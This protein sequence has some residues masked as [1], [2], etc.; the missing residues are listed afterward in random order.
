MHATHTLYSSEA[1]LSELMPA[2]DL[3]IGAVLVPGAR[4]PRLIS[5]A[6]LRSMKPGS[7]FVDIAIDQG[8]CAETSRPTTHDDPTYVEEGV[9][10]YCVANMPGAYARTATQ[11]L[12]NVTYPYIEALAEHGLNAA[13]RKFDGLADGVNVHAGKL[14]CDAVARAHGL[15]FTPFAPTD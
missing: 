7:V 9:L 8:G 14:T 3:L 12:T 5:R 15:P 11:A 13:C 6:M 10:H 4:A 2:V 1:H